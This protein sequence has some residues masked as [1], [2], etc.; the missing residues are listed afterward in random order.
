MKSLQDFLWLFLFFLITYIN[1]SKFYKQNF[2]QFVYFLNVFVF[3]LSSL[4]NN[5]SHISIMT[6]CLILL[7]A[8]LQTYNILFLE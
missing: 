7:F 2:L 1:Q 5:T 8:L 6:G 3:I 4:F